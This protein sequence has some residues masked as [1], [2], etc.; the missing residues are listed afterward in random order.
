VSFFIGIWA[1]DA[2]LI[3]AVLLTFALDALHAPRGTDRTTP[4]D[5]V[6]E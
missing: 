3:L 4:G 1:L 6:E 5:Y 2:D